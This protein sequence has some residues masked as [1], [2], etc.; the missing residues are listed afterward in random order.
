MEFLW[1]ERNRTGLLLRQDGI[2]RLIDVV[3]REV[4]R[5]YLL[6]PRAAPPQA[7][8]SVEDQVLAGIEHGHLGQALADLSPELR[9]AI[10]A[11]VLVC[12][13]SGRIGAGLR[14]D[15]R[16]VAAQHK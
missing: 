14:G 9:A 1:N 7:V 12:R 6:G 8:V 15:A 11:T 5:R 3:R 13:R 16:P 4:G 10:E 2:R